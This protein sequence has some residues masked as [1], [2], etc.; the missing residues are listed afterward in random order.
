M[1][2]NANTLDPADLDLPL[3]ELLHD[4]SMYG[5]SSKEDMEEFSSEP[6]KFYLQFLD[7]G[8]TNEQIA[9]QVYLHLMIYRPLE[10]AART[11]ADKYGEDFT[12]RFPELD[13]TAALE[14]DMRHWLGE[15]WEE[16]A[17][18][19]ERTRAYHERIKEVCPDSIP[20]F[21]A[22]QYTRYLGDLSGGQYIGKRFRKA[23]GLEEDHTGAEFYDFTE[24]EGGPRVFKKK[25]KAALDAYPFTAEERQAIVDEVCLV[26]RLNNR[27]A[28]DLEDTL[29]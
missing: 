9:A 22:H 1:S 4:I 15:N 5:H 14:R 7:G 23:Y 20:M 28:L 10:N 11:L 12:F 21:V 2:D 8:L 27:A 29:N 16:K 3:S 24:L 18:A 26:Y 25:Y 6:G 19:G 17:S 13:R